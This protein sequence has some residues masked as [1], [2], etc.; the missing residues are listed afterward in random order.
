MRRQMGMNINL[1]VIR[2]NQKMLGYYGPGV[3][4]GKNL[5]VKGY[6]F[7]LDIIL[8]YQKSSLSLQKKILYKQ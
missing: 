7:L 4:E 8:V 6:N 1:D 2:R 3:E 5:K